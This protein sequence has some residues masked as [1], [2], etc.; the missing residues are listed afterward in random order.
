M[1]ALI[2]FMLALTAIVLLGCSNPETTAPIDPI[3]PIDPIINDLDISGVTVPVLGATPVTTI[4]DTQYT[5]TV[6]WNPLDNGKFGSDTI[7]T[8]FIKLTAKDGYYFSEIEDPFAFS[9]E[10]AE[11]VFYNVDTH[12]ITA[13][14]R[15]IANLSVVSDVSLS[16]TSDTSIYFIGVQGGSIE[17]SGSADMTVSSFRMSMNEITGEQYA[18]VVG[19][20]DPSGFA[21]IGGDNPVE[22]ITWYDAVDF[23]NKLSVLDEL[24][25][26]YTITN[27]TP[28]IGYPITA[29]AVSAD[30]SANG[31]RLPT[32]AEWEFAARGGNGH[33]IYYTNYS[34]SYEIN[35]VAWYYF[36][37]ND[38]THP[39]GLRN[40][41]SLGF[42]DM[43]GNVWE[44]CWD[45]ETSLPL[46]GGHTDYRGAASGTNRVVRGGC[47]SDFSE[48]CRV[49]VRASDDPSCWSQ[50]TGFRV[51]RP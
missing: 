34:G 21:I 26:V 48:N 42:K 19:R 13:S 41:N 22:Q 8:A 47:W 50:Y 32:E 36:N 10:G 31:Y 7:I 28:L 27:R 44:W 14:F 49:D 15:A 1:K 51:V 24:I 2:M 5:G 4:T 18:A 6:T 37:S 9:V 20:A 45:L 39:V 11:S 38:S 16:V 23:C 12:E 25:P 30:W 29:A 43:S 40:A 33:G 17:R 3:V 46:Y 35:D